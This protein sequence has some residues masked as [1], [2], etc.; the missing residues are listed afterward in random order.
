MVG[1]DGEAC[2]VLAMSSGWDC[3]GCEGADYV[4]YEVGRGMVNN[5]MFC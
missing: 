2:F 1:G 5:S 4:G 3:F